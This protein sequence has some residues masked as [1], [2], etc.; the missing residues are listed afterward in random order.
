MSSLGLGI[1]FAPRN[2]AL[3]RLGARKK[4]PQEASEHD[5]S[6]I[7]SPVSLPLAR[8]I[9]EGSQTEARNERQARTHGESARKAAQA[10]SWRHYDDVSDEDSDGEDPD[11]RSEQYGG[12]EHAASILDSYSSTD[13]PNHLQPFAPT[14]YTSPPLSRVSPGSAVHSLAS[15]S[16]LPGSAGSLFMRRLMTAQ[17]RLEEKSHA[18]RQ[19]QSMG[20]LYGGYIGAGMVVAAMR[21][22]HGPPSL[23]LLRAQHIALQ[24]AMRQAPSPSASVDSKANSG[25]PP[26]PSRLPA[27]LQQ[28]QQAARE[29]LASPTKTFP[30]PPSAAAA[31]TG[32]PLP[33]TFELHLPM[34]RL[35]SAVRTLERPKSMLELSQVYG[36]LENQAS[37]KRLDTLATPGSAD[38]SSRSYRQ[39]ASSSRTDRSA[40]DTASLRRDATEGRAESARRLTRS[41][42]LRKSKSQ[43]TLGRSFGAIEGHMLLRPNQNPTAP[44]ESRT[45]AG[46]AGPPR[47]SSAVGPASMKMRGRSLSE[48]NTLARQS[49]LLSSGTNP[50]HHARELSRL[51]APTSNEAKAS[52]AASTK[53]SL[54]NAAKVVALEGA[55]PAS[56][57]RVDMDLVLESSLVVEGGSLKGRM[58]IKVAAG[59]KKHGDVWMAEPK[60]RVVGFEGA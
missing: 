53:A 50:S 11:G 59:D 38:M 40:L 32:A 5:V 17:E 28:R 14:V 16:T 12:S 26:S 13:L 21:D 56:K 57:A 27:F 7:F 2:P 46:P 36:S 4:R 35:R 1:D 39:L 43:G 49:T 9:S 3:D 52:S 18:L 31:A 8:Q 60:I 51:L 19:A 44:I 30:M 54:S 29:A 20:D 48:G 25:G 55:K 6:A 10:E 47:P 37:R 23:D 41:A 45:D 42:G 22:H 24:G 34:A 58:E 15:D 33:A